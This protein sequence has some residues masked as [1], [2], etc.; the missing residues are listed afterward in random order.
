MAHRCAASLI[1]SHLP[2]MLQGPPPKPVMT[3]PLCPELTDSIIDYLYADKNSLF[4]CGLTCKTWLASSRYHLFSTVKL[5]SE[6]L[7]SFNEL[8]NYPSNNITFVVRHLAIEFGLFIFGSECR[9]Q[10]ISDFPILL[11]IT[12]RLR[13]VKFLSLKWIDWRLCSPNILQDM[14]SNWGGV[15][16]LELHQVVFMN[17]EKAI[18]FICG[19][20]LLNSLSLDIL[21]SQPPSDSSHTTSYPDTPSF[22]IKFINLRPNLPSAFLDW[23][24]SSIPSI[25]TLRCYPIVSEEYSAVRHALA[26]AG[27]FIQEIEFLLYANGNGLN[28]EYTFLAILSYSEH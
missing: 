10:M 7:S 5:T 20:P 9:E 11:N 27:P 19:F 28:S 25:R 15:E 23:I 24:L 3:P 17:S 8:V 4:A 1:S 2:N 18:N 12:A 14:L 6:N 16:T 13:M 22:L 21:M 26:S